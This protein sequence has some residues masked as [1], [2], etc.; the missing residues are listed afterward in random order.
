RE[1]EDMVG[2]Q[3]LNIARTAALLVDPGTHARLQSAPG[4][5]PEAYAR[6]QRSLAAVQPETVLATH[7]Y[8]LADYDRAPRRARAGVSTGAQ[9]AG[10]PYAVGPA[11]VDPLGWT[12][13]DGV[14]RYTGVYMGAKGS[15]ITAFAPIVQADKNIA[16]LVVDYP[17]EIFLDRS[18]ELG[19]A[20]LQGT[21]AGGLGALVLGLL[22]ARR[23]TRPV[24]ALTDGVGRVA[25]GGPPQTPP[26]RAAGEMRPVH[27][28]FH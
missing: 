4:V 11:L 25:G 14:A 9:R 2:T 28:A 13:E 3:L 12:L 7:I 10:Q 19:L 8:T 27:P 6:L 5:D 24:S 22:F 17:V 20:I 26:L 18:R 21:L 15:M 23:I 16:V 1:V